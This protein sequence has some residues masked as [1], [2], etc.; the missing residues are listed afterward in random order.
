[1]TMAAEQTK[2]IHSHA[3]DA[4]ASAIT[5]GAQGTSMPNRRKPH[6]KALNHGD[7]DVFDVNAPGPAGEAQPQLQVTQRC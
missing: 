1:M 3:A 4:L 2:I 5:A 7:Y 6:G